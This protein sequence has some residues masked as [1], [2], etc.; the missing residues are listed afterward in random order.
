MAT[1]SEISSCT[2]LN[3]SATKSDRIQMHGNAPFRI[4]PMECESIIIEIFEWLSPHTSTKPYEKLIN[5]GCYDL[6][7]RNRQSAYISHTHTISESVLEPIYHI[8]HVNNSS[9]LKNCAMCLERPRDRDMSYYNRA[10]I[11]TTNFIFNF[12]MPINM[13]IHT[14]CPGQSADIICVENILMK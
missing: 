5:D 7:L 12:S 6:W 3:S 2:N 4:I 10:I 13:C 1:K 14:V 9:D 8:K 11:W